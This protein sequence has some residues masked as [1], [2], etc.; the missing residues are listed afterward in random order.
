VDLDG[1]GELIVSAPNVFYL[2]PAVS[3]DGRQLAWMQRTPDTD[4]WLLEEKP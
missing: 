3:P 1:R 4:V 2:Y